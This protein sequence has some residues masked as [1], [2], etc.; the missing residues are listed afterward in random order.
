MMP[1][2]QIDPTGSVTV[3]RSIGGRQGIDI[4]M[5]KIEKSFK[6]QVEHG[7]QI[8]SRCSEENDPE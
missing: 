6:I 1:F 3:G 4:H 7:C 8:R 2:E 5:S